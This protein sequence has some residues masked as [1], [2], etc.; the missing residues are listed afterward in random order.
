M[1]RPVVAL[2][3]RPNVGKSTLFNRLVGEREAITED[4]PGTT[5]DRLYGQADW[6]GR[7]FTIV[8]TGGLDLETE[9]GI[10]AGIRQ[11]AQIAIREA[12]VI[13]FLV[14]ARS[15]L[16]P[17]DTDVA[18]VLRR[19]DKPV[20]VV[21]NKAESEQRQM[22]AN[23]FY[24]LGFEEVLPTSAYHGR[25]IDDLLDWIV[26]HLPPRAEDEAEEPAEELEVRVAIIGRPNVGKSSLLN[27][28]LGEERALVSDLPGT[29]RDA[30]DT[31][32]ERDG[33]RYRLIDT[34]GIR[35]RGKIEHGAAEQY[36][37][38]RA[39]R[40]LERCDVAVLLLDAVEGITDGD[41]H[42][43]GFARDRFKGLVVV[44]NKWDLVTKEPGTAED[45][46]RHVRQRLHFMPY[47]PVLFASVLTGF[48]LPRILEEVTRIWE[49]RQRRIGTA[50]LNAF[51]QTVLSRHSVS[52][53][54]K[55]L[56]VLYATQAAVNPPTFVLFVNDRTLA[57]FGYL[58]Y[59]E[60]ELRRAFGFDGTPIKLVLRG[61]QE[62]DEPAAP[63]QRRARR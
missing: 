38:L 23:E 39:M 32:L 20:L 35:R 33:F 47:V 59:V 56:K 34:A 44:V 61:R 26:T 41:L 45:Y 6:E 62:E 15:G 54:G 14:D 18:G 40:A 52:R 17:T 55:S 43:A 37:V 11:Q 60:N 22:A 49:E 48:H 63:G 4:V 57:H 10:P 46:A 28:L 27:R 31:L 19:S 16:L 50:E 3:G 30:T 12:D 58:R 1:A 24:A 7:V 29:T 9:R 42:I 5:R 36:S 13:L 51:V 21:A 2:V 25:G 8:D 53:G